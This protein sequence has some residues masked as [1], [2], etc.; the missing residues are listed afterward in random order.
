MTVPWI[1]VVETDEM[2]V[3]FVINI[4]IVLFHANLIT[5][6]FTGYSLTRSLIHQNF[7]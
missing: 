1:M 6:A 2:F 3:L 4:F 5:K 7:L